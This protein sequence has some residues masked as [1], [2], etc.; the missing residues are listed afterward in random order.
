[1]P[2]IVIPSSRGQ[3]QGHKNWP[4]GASGLRAGLE[5]YITGYRWH[6]TCHQCRWV[7]ICSC[8]KLL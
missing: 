3:G 8:D 4:Q 1:M 5:D 2:K 6:I 7:S